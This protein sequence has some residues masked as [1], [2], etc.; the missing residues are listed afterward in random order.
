[1]RYTGRGELPF[2]FAPTLWVYFIQMKTAIT[3]LS[4]QCVDI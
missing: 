1:M 3:A 2:G 4:N